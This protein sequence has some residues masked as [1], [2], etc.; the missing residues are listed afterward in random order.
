LAYR[1]FFRKLK[2]RIEHIFLDP[3]FSDRL[4][5]KAFL[6]KELPIEKGQWPGLI[7]AQPI[8]LGEWEQWIQGLKARSMIGYSLV[9]SG[10]QPFYF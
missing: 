2:S 3:K 1:P 4:E 9:R 5:D 10:F 7:P 6:K 8:G